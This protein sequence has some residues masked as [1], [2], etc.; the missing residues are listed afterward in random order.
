VD[1]LWEVRDNLLHTVATGYDRLVAIGDMTWQEYEEEVPV[2]IH[3]IRTSGDA[4]VGILVRWNGHTLLNTLP[5]VEQPRY[6]HPLGALAWYHRSI[7]FPKY[8]F[9]ILGEKPEG[10]GGDFEIIAEDR[11]HV[12]FWQAGDTYILKVRAEIT[13]AG[14]SYYKF[15]A[16]EDGTPEPSAW[17]L[18]G[19]G[20]DRYDHE[21]HGSLLLVAHQI[22]ASFGTVEITPLGEG[23]SLSVAITGQGTVTKEPNK[24]MYNEGEQV[25]LT[26][27]ADHDQEPVPGC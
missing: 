4:G 16:W 17:T 18:E 27:V 11:S 25:T 2:T 10:G 9:E 5:G 8:R 23:Y 20:V 7:S 13:P 14:K 6:G 3:R 26:L 1:G 19:P 12:D 15:K 21:L 22:D 24:A